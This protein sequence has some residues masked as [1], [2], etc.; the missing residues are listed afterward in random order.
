MINH[1]QPLFSLKTWL[2]DK[3]CNE[4]LFQ[5]L[6]LCDCA[7]AES[8]PCTLRDAAP[9][10]PKFK[11]L[12]LGTLFQECLLV[13]MGLRSSLARDYGRATNKCENLFTR[14]LGMSSF[15]VGVE[16]AKCCNRFLWKIAQIT[17]CQSE[18]WLL[19]G[20]C[21]P[22][23]MFEIVHPIPI[24]ENSYGVHL[25]FSVSKNMSF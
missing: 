10:L 1:C 21:S 17:V 5:G 13:A 20:I 8:E 23:F 9:T 22:I 4:A 12:G 25:N 3:A 19:S 6:L 11:E 24:S 2:S 7:R 18:N 16:Q 15:P 14:I